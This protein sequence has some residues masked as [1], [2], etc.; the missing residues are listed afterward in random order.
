PKAEGA[1]EQ[2]ERL[3]R[4]EQCDD[5]G[6]PA[7]RGAACFPHTRHD[8][9]DLRLMAPAAIDDAS[10]ALGDECA[11]GVVAKLAPHLGAEHVVE[12]AAPRRQ[13]ACCE[14]GNSIPAP[15]RAALGAAGQAVLIALD[16]GEAVQADRAAAPA[17]PGA[18]PLAAERLPMTL[19]APV[20]GP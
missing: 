14:R 4:D 11:A 1:S 18:R 15:R 19:D 6:R 9:G 12:E 2:H 7:A 17:E 20:G 3:P 5:Q 13:F 10:E 8:L 16:A